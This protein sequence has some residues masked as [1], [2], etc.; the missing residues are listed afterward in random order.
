MQTVIC[1]RWGTRYGVQFVNRLY[2]MVAR[3]TERPLRFICMTDDPQG[4]AAG[5]EA[6]PLPPIDLPEDIRWSPWRKLAI[7]QDP[8]FDITGDVLFLDID[9]LVTGSI[10]GFFDFAP[11]SSFCV[12]HNWT[13][14]RQRIGNTSCFRFRVGS[15]THIYDRFMTEQADVLSKYRIE[16]VYISAEI[17]EMTFWPPDWCVSFKH[18]LLPKWPLRFIK[19]PSLPA[20]TRIV[21]FTGKP[22]PDEARDGVWPSKWY[23][24]F[25]KHV[26]PTPWIAEHWR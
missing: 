16:Q 19:S 15:H 6:K 26:R 14:P 24:R 8:L 25:Y 22:D 4:L 20:N 18:S 7:W 21:A 1:M 2:A 10:D 23:K 3:N 9:L 5:I 17:C 12:I 13:Q 11:D